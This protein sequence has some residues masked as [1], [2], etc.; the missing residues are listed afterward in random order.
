MLLEIFNAFAF[1]GATAFG[2]P[3]SHIA[4]MEIEFVERRKWLSLDRFREHMATAA[5]LPG[6]TSTELAL[7]IGQ[8]RGGFPGLLMA[9]CGFILPAFALV[10]AIAMLLGRQSMTPAFES[11]MRGIQ[12]VLIAII[13]LSLVKLVQSVF[14]HRFLYVC[15]LAALVA[16][17]LGQNILL[18]LFGAGVLNL[19]WHR[20]VRRPKKF[21]ATLAA[22]L[23]AWRS[24]SMDCRAAEALSVAASSA[25][26][27]DW[28]LLLIFLKIGAVFYGGGYMLLAFLR[29]DFVLHLNVISEHELMTAVSVGQ[30]TPGP[31]FTAATFIGYRL[32][33]LAGA[34]LA[35]VGIFAPAFLYAGASRFFVPSLRKSSA[36]THL[37]DGVNA[38]SCALMAL[39]TWHL[40][41]QAL[42]DWKTDVI[43]AG[44]ML[45]LLRF[46]LNA[47]WLVLAGGVLGFALL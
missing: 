15:A 6:P 42:V 13:V 41:R 1:L 3:A 17:C 30:F 19:L 20:V 4:L 38:A 31:L 44:A 45:L 39:V 25:P 46:K 29:E 27:G 12:P 32:N 16:G 9:G 18:I 23:V 14:K 10:L 47:A 37:L 22:M 36:V 21:S 7:L 34:V 40:Q 5:L 11:A 33:G 8:E 24:S 28:N 26:V 2:G 43:A 35:T